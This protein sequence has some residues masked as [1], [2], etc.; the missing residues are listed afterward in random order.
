MNLYFIL[1]ELFILG[2]TLYLFAYKQ[3]LAVLYIPVILFARITIEPLTPAFLYYT[4]VSL[5]ILYLAYKNA[6]FLRENIF[7]LLLIILYAVLVTQTEDFET[8]RSSFFAL[9]W[10][11]LSIPLV[12]AIYKKHD[13]DTVMEEL[14]SAAFLILAVFIVNVAFSTVFSYSPKLMYGITSGIL[15]GNLYATDFNILGIAVFIV[16]WNA[17]SKRNLLFLA[18][19]IVAIAFIMLSF[20][21]SVMGTTMLGVAAVLL[22]LFSQHSF[23]KTALFIVLAL[24]AGF[25]IVMNTSFVDVFIARYEQRKLDERELGEET[26]FLEYDILYQDIDRKSVV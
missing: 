9:I 10:L 20:R 13:K 21:R 11:F 14:A 19:S 7:A 18:T 4:I 22:I 23:R 25:V 1:I 5:L 8:I 16:L 3:E 2:L 15:Y 12:S 26:R 24:F 17:I 6:G